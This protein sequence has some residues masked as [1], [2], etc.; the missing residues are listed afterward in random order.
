MTKPNTHDGGMRTL[1]RVGQVAAA[2]LMLHGCYSTSRATFW[3][4]APKPDPQLVAAEETA[5]A[6]NVQG[7]GPGDVVEVIAPAGVEA[8]YCP[9]P[10]MSAAAPRAT[11]KLPYGTVGRVSA[12]FYPNISLTTAG[13]WFVQVP[14]SYVRRTARPMPAPQ[15]RV[16]GYC[17]GKGA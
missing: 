13:G 4:A 1:V 5:K 12:Y 3:P 11:M 16:R 15:G 17:I 7:L 10:S 6:A 2:A 14:A 9:Q 8:S